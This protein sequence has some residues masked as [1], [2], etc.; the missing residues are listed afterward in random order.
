MIGGGVGRC[1]WRARGD[2][3]LDVF[4]GEPSELSFGEGYR[5]TTSLLWISG[6][7]RLFKYWSSRNYIRLDSLQIRFSNTSDEVYHIGASSLSC[8]RRSNT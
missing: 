6:T 4:F 1:R 8:S 5:I 7:V 3:G 2:G